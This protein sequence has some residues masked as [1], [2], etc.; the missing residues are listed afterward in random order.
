MYKIK[1][2]RFFFLFFFLVW[3]RIIMN[4]IMSVFCN[5]IVRVLKVVKFVVGFKGLIV[6]NKIIL[7]NFGLFVVVV[8]L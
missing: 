7:K 6:D 4:V 1:I 2:D 3:E 8:C 5:V